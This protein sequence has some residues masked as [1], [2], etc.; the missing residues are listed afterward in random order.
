[1]IILRKITICFQINS[2]NYFILL[3]RQW[4]KTK[5]KQRVDWDIIF[6]FTSPHALFWLLLWYFQFGKKKM[7]KYVIWVTLTG[8]KWWS[9]RT[10]ICLIC[11]FSL[12]DLK[13]R[14]FASKDLQIMNLISI[15]LPFLELVFLQPKL[16]QK[17]QR[18]LTQFPTRSVW[19]F[20][21]SLSVT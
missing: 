18:Y 8:W 1:M 20:L 9:I 7:M 11:P 3:P 10:F 17:Y 21:M 6:C 4:N 15:S 14:K 5:L 12:E 2:R 13:L 19:Y 16:N